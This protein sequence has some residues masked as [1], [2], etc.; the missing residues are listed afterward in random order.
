MGRTDTAFR[1]L[2][3]EPEAI[4]RALVYPAAVAQWLPPGGMTARIDT[5][6]P[7]PGGSYRMT[8]RYG[9]VGSGKSTADSDVISGRFVELVPGERVVQDAEFVSDDPAFGGT[10]RMTWT[11]RATEVGTEVRIR[12]DDVPPGITAED[13]AL[14]LEGS[15]ANLAEFVTRRI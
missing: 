8:L 15:L 6:D 12:A 14:G 5:W 10:M 2:A 9:L 13:H 1:V 7:R 4:Y 3:A 11:L